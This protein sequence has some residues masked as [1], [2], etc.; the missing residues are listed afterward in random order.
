MLFSLV[1]LATT[2]L[3]AIPGLA[4]RTDLTEHTLVQCRAVKYTNAS[5]APAEVTATVKHTTT[6]L[7][8]LIFR[9][10]RIGDFD[11][12]P[13][14]E[15]YASGAPG[16]SGMVHDGK[17]A[18]TLK[19]EAAAQSYYNGRLDETV[20][21]AVAES[22]IYC[23]YVAGDSDTAR[24]AVALASR[25][26]HGFLDYPTYV[27]GRH[28]WWFVA[29]G[30]ALAAYMLHYVVR[31]QVGREF[32]MSSVSLVTHGL[33][34]FLLVPSVVVA[35]V[36]WACAA[37]ANRVAWLSS[38]DAVPMA[39]ALCLL[40]AFEAFVSYAVLMFAMGY[41]VIFGPRDT[42]HYRQMPSSLAARARWMLVGDV[43]T[44]ALRVAL[45]TLGLEFGRWRGLETA[46][47]ALAVVSATWP[48]VWLVMQ[49]KHYFGTKHTIA[50]FPP[51]ADPATNDALLRAF[52][53]SVLVI[54]VIPLLGGLAMAAILV[55]RIA[56]STPGDPG[57]LPNEAATVHSA[58]EMMFNSLYV[59]A[60]LWSNRLTFYA[61]VVAMFALW[62]RHNYGIKREGPSSEV[63]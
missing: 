63:I 16:G 8:V 34:F 62:T 35:A 42:P 58:E 27:V 56:Q 51:A 53:R 3:G 40:H 1:F 52:R 55:R 24:F 22:G 30:T 31:S 18:V 26:S 14:M 19:P 50:A 60:L 49:L 12:I 48:M 46:Q 7:T 11:G 25:N 45:G 2:V 13:R 36:V 4:D 5:A 57:S 44:Y 21:L 47:V 10:S 59:L 39:V 61:I 9:Y 43:G 6:P 20:T 15:A 17:F 33:V 38:A 37:V 41:G 28:Q 29:I 32:N 23:A 54:F